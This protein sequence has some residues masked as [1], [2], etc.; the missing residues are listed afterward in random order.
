MDTRVIESAPGTRRWWIL[1]AVSAAQLLV[2]LDGTIVNIALPSAQQALGMSD[3]SRLGILLAAACVAGPLI[4]TRA[5]REKRQ[6][7][8]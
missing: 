8:R 3:G 4:A 1:S 5:A 2:V 6:S 7:T